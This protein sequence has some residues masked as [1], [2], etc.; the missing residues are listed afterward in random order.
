[1]RLFLGTCRVNT[2]PARGLVLIAAKPGGRNDRNVGANGNK[3]L[4]HNNG[5]R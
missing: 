2:N 1:M 3:S 5:T 4:L